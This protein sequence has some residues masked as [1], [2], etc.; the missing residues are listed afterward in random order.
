MP[1]M[2]G[3]HPVRRTLQYLKAGKLVLKDRIKILS[4]N[5]NTHGDHHLGARYVYKITINVF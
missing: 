3:S 5:Y 4:V 2:I 1:F